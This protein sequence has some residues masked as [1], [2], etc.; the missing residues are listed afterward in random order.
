MKSFLF[1]CQFAQPA[2]HLKKIFVEF[3][4]QYKLNNGIFVA[5]LSLKTSN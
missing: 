2:F 5:I 1:S 3:Y 4:L